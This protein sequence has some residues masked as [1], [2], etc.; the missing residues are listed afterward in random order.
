MYPV[1]N[2]ACD[3]RVLNFTSAAWA[4]IKLAAIGFSDGSHTFRDIC[5]G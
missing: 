5:A 3:T 1:K 4:T 2:P